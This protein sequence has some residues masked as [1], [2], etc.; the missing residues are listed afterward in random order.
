M[1]PQRVYADSL[2]DGARQYELERLRQG[3]ENTVVIASSAS[4]NDLATIE[5]AVVRESTGATAPAVNK[6][7]RAQRALYEVAN[8]V[9]KTQPNATAKV[10]ESYQSVPVQAAT[11]NGSGELGFQLEMDE[12]D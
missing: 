5:D 2:R 9:H 3:Y 7:N 11:G 8:K 4:N 6:R 10:K 12:L 1:D